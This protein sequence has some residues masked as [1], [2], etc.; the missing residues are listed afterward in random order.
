MGHVVNAENSHLRFALRTF[1]DFYFVIDWIKVC[2]ISVRVC[3]S[4]TPRFVLFGVLFLFFCNLI[5]TC[6]GGA[7]EDSGVCVS[8]T[9]HLLKHT[10]VSVF[11]QRQTQSFRPISTLVSISFK[12]RASFPSKLA[13][14]WLNQPD[15]RGSAPL[16]VATL[17]QQ[18]HEA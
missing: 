17:L 16:S 1:A 6:G 18:R 2:Y 15:W 10:N 12:E 11:T 5:M 13:F 3:C 14:V 4:R 7:V 8:S 9:F